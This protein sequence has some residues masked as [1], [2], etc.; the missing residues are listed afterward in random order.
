MQAEA[1]RGGERWEEGGGGLWWQERST[2]PLT[3]GMFC[4]NKFRTHCTDTWYLVWPS[5]FQKVD[6]TIQWVKL[7]LL[8]SANYW[9]ALILIH[10]IVIYTVD[11]A[12]QPLNKWGLVNKIIGS[13]L[14]VSLLQCKTT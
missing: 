1:L 2:P 6:N 3:A 14:K 7:Y 13:T 8:D 10:W 4:R 5:F 9:F 12:T 11:S